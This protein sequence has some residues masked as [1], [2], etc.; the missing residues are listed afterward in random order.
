MQDETMNLYNIKR[1]PHGYAI[2]KF[3]EALNLL[4][5][6]DTSAK[7]C[8]C[9]AGPR[10]TCRHRKMLPR[11]LGNVDTD[12]FYC[13]ETNVWHRPLAPTGGNVGSS[14]PEPK[15]YGKMDTS[16][17][18]AQREMNEITRV[19]AEGL[20]AEPPKPQAAPTIRR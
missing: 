9:P 12:A 2:A 16:L 20:A 11:M 17:L 15:A 18:E 14:T 13:Y 10:P 4:A 5:A 6:Y 19:H 1:G 7:S 8:S 3:D